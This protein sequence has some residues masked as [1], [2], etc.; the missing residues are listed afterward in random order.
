MATTYFATIRKEDYEAFRRL[1]GHHLPDT[2]DEWT[3]LSND[4]IH[5][6]M[7][8]SSVTGRGI[9]VDPGEFAA[10]LTTHRDQRTLD[11]LRN[12]AFEKRT[13]ADEE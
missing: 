4:R 10:W 9:E 11:G 12:F 7:R 2:Y 13:A 5:Q 1:L 8:S 3:N 6:L